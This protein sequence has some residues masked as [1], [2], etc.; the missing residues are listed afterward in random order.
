MK[1]LLFILISFVSLSALFTGILLMG[2]PDGSILDL[3]LSL[4]KNTPFDDFQIPGMLL[5][6]LVGGVNMLA[7]FYNIKR[8][9]KRYEYAFW[10]GFSL[11][12]WVIAQFLIINISLWFDLF[13]LTIGISIILL[14][15]QL[16]GKTLY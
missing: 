6:I 9:E 3:S 7:V 1:T 4:L 5:A 11:V 15:L 10:G 14:A 12:I 13:Y 16:K 2:V 8:D